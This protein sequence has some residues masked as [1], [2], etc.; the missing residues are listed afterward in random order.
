[1]ALGEYLHLASGLLRLGLCGCRCPPSARHQ[2]RRP[3]SP[4]DRHL[5]KPSFPRA[6]RNPRLAS[7]AAPAC[8]TA[9]LAATAGESGPDGAV[10]HPGRRDRDRYRGGQGGAGRGASPPATTTPGSPRAAPGTAPSAH[11]P[12]GSLAEAAHQSEGDAGPGQ[13]M[14]RLLLT[15]RS[16]F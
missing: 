3:G 16:Y 4:G 9:L 8:V 14:G 6:A 7:A 13:P 1:M 2:G 5:H 10:E 11:T 12:F 15:R